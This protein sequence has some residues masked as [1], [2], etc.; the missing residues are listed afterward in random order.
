[1]ASDKTL[2]A[3]NLAVLGAERLADL[4]LELAGVTPLQNVGFALNW[5]A[6]LAAMMSSP[7][8]VSGW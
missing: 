6:D 5:P 4:L 3:K 1:M 2:N 7:K 8:S